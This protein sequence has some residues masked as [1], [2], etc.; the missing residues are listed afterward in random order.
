[1]AFIPYIKANKSAFTIFSENDHISM[2]IRES[3]D[4]IGNV[5]ESGYGAGR[6]KYL[7]ECLDSILVWIF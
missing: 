1:M 5:L 2:L 3:L 4:K 7:G 6:V